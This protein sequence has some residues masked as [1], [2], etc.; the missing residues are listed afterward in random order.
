[1]TSILHKDRINIK[2]VEAEGQVQDQPVWYSEFKASLAY[3]RKDPTS[4]NI[5]K[6]FYFV[7]VCV[8]VCVHSLLDAH[9]KVRVN[10]VELILSF[11][12]VGS[13]V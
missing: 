5:C 13:R 7:C 9:V 3:E 11:Y 12:H 8:C 2:Q 6:K 4:K 10:F 1:M